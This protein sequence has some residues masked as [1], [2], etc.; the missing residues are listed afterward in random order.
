MNNSD[1]TVL[2]AQNFNN[3][4]ERLGE[5]VPLH[6]LLIYKEGNLLFEKYDP[7]FDENTIHRLFSV[8]KTLT[9]IAIGKLACDGKINLKDR[10]CTYFP[11]KFP[12][13]GDEASLH[14]WIRETTIENCLMMRTPHAVTTYRLGGR[15]DY[16][17]SFFT[18][19]PT[20]RPGRIFCY[21]TSGSHVLGAL[22]EKLSGKS[23]P[24]F[25]RDELPDLGLSEDAYFITDPQGVSLGGTGLC[26]ASRDLLS[27]GKFILNA[28]KEESPFGEFMRKASSCLTSNRVPAPIPG[29]SFGYGYYLWRCAN[30]TFMCY[31]MGGQFVFICP[32]HK[33]LMITTAN[34]QGRAGSNQFFHDEFGALVC[35]LDNEA[36]LSVNAKPSHSFREGRGVFA[37]LSVSLEEIL[38]TE[39]GCIGAKAL[40]SRINKTYLFT[41]NEKGFES[42]TLTD[43]ELIL[44]LREPSPDA[45]EGTVGGDIVIPLTEGSEFIFPG[46]IQRTA[47][48]LE[49]LSDGTVLLTISLIDSYLGDFLL[50]L[51]FT[52]EDLVVFM[53]KRE[54]S[55]L[56]NFNG[57]IYGKIKE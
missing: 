22:I 14:P 33:L 40:K 53:L 19:E 25:I 4:F 27:L 30:D 11:E 48:K 8:S 49:L 35:A 7:A 1:S 41:E 34:T 2:S 50:Q 32:R 51:S 45:P 16:V 10:V 43:D 20:H 47:A 37:P 28:L 55:V 46:I 57:Q 18:H 23:I 17:G 3:I 9:A 42:L 29:E 26:G 39:P 21:D 52:D 15:E 31:G 36:G 24:D 56:P 6:S 13:P 12:V 54:E 5:R 44:T 38:S